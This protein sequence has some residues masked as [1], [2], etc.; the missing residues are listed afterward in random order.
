MY[1]DEKLIFIN[2]ESSGK[3]ELLEHLCGKLEQAGIVE[4]ASTFFTA[5]WE[6]EESFSTGIGRNVAIPHGKSSSVRD[7]KLLV[8]IIP[9]GVEYEALDGEPVKI[10]FMFAVPLGRDKE[11]MSLLGKV[12]TFVRDESNRNKL[13]DVK[14]EQELLKEIREVIN[15]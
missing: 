8:A 4:S 12:T 15:D 11:Y 1:I 9:K 6:R 7:T 2:I 3:R 14:S 10:L 13:L 5:I